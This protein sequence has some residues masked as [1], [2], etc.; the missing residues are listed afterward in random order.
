MG[1]DF[2]TEL[3]DLISAH[4]A[5]GYDLGEMIADLQGAL[6]GLSEEDAA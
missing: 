5:R 1:K 6:D 3:D 4:K 2:S